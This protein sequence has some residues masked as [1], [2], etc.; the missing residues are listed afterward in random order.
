M[1]SL[2]V[3]INSVLAVDCRSG[4]IALVP[5][6][7]DHQRFKG[8]SLAMD[9]M[10]GLAAAAKALEIAKQ[11]KEVNKQLSE[12]EFKL[13]IAELYESLADVKMALADA[14]EELATKEKLD[15][16]R[17]VDYGGQTFVY[18]LKASEVGEESPQHRICAACYQQGKIGH[19]QF[20]FHSVDSGQDWFECSVCKDRRAYGGARR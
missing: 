2:S 17:L 4:A 9:I 3:E 13:K 16:Y 12:A 15:R 14:K 18:E 11:L 20:E 5:P 6:I 8:D 19:L 7:A 1:R 10:L